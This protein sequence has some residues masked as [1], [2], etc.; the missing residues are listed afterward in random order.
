MLISLYNFSSS[1]LVH[2]LAVFTSGYLFLSFLKVL[3]KDLFV[4]L[5]TFSTVI[6]SSLSSSIIFWSFLLLYLQMM[7]EIK[8]SSLTLPF[9][10]VFV[11]T[12]I[13]LSTVSFE[14]ISSKNYAHNSLS[15]FFLFFFVNFNHWN[16]WG[17]HGV[18]LF[19][20]RHIFK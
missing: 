13:Y 9:V 4:I 17:T 8:S 2:F 1:S 10:F 6:I 3:E 7:S 14:L 11:V 18:G 5:L 16:L 12:I 19:T 15:I 20:Q